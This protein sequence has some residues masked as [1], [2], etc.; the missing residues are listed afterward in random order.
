[1]KEGR[2]RLIGQLFYTFLR[3][4]P[5]TF[6]GG[7]AMI[8]V[9]ERE[10]AVKRQWIE[11]RE[12]A[13]V[14]SV[15]GSAP[16]G[17]GVN[18]AAFIGYR[19]A[20]V[21]GAVSAV[22]GITLPTF[23]IAVLLSIAYTVFGGYAKI[24]AALQGI[25]AAVFGLIL[26]A[27]YKMGRNAIYDLTTFISAVCTVVLLISASVHPLFLIISGIWAGIACVIVKQKLGM[28]V[29]LSKDA[30]NGPEKGGNPAPK[31]PAYADYFIADGI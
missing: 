8:P 28:V 25:Q 9:L 21:P 4:G 27:A 18:A 29:R 3:M 30:D 5:V 10:V 20:G 23:I 7:Y 22:A 16:G 6:G 17:I 31:A 14:L 26:V 11:E 2:L 24:E 13:E 19:L 15:A 12:M 1:M